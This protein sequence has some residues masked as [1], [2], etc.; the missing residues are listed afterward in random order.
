MEIELLGKGAFMSALV[1][2]DSGEEFISESGAMYRASS[3]VDI[4]I[5]TKSRKKGGVFQALKRLFAGE[6]FFFSTY[7]TSDGQSGEVG[8]AP[9][10]Q[11]GMKILPLDGSAAWMTTGGSYIGSSKDVLVE[12]EFQ[13]LK[14]LFTGE[15]IFFLKASGTGQILVGAFGRLTEIEVNEEI[16]VDTGH[17]VAFQ[18]T[19][20]YKITK[21][22]KGWFQS[23]LTGEGMVMKFSGKGRIVVQSH[24]PD[25]F[26]K[27]LGPILPER[28]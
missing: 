12:T 20:E 4:D 8:L 24:N 9:T 25:E 19:L 14:G 6:H 18:D 21:A 26:G 22:G 11:G 27:G 7:K 2:L 13:G 3:N 1:H 5:T 23:W 16:I 10:H 28:D 15:N 17:V